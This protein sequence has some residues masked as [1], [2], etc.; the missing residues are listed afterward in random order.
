MQSTLDMGPVPAP[1]P[2]K[3]VKLLKDGSLSPCLPPSEWEEA[4]SR[5]FVFGM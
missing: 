4:G 1:T 3:E 5:L 2:H